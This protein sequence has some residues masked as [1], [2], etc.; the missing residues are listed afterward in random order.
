M[1]ETER[2]Q[3]RMPEHTKRR[4]DLQKSFTR[5]SNNEFGLRAIEKALDDLGIP[6]DVEKLR[7]RKPAKQS[8]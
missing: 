8:A 7:R 1:P 3:I 2:L 6:A 5:L 4:V